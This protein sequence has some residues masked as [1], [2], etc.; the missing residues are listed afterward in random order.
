MA[1]YNASWTYRVQVTI[2][3][4]QVDSDLTDFPVYVDLS[5]LP[6][7]FFT[8]VDSAGD[9]IRVTRADGTTECAF[10]LVSINTGGSTGE[11]HFKANFI[12]STSDTSFYIY[13]GNAVA[14]AYAVGA[15]YGR[16]AV[17][18]DYDMVWHGGALTDSTGNQTLTANGGMTIGGSIGK[19]GSASSFDGTDD[20]ISFGSVFGNTRP[21]TF[22]AWAKLNTGEHIFASGGGKALISVSDTSSSSDQFLLFT[23]RVGSDSLWSAGVLE[24]QSGNPGFGTTTSSAGNVDDDVWEHWVGKI[25]S[26][27]SRTAYLNGTAGTENTYTQSSSSL[28]STDIGRLGDSTPNYY[29]DGDLCEVRVISSGLSSDWIAAEYTNQN[30]PNTFYTVGSQESGPT[31]WLPS[32]IIL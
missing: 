23:H 7:G 1:W 15:T 8:N 11:L 21:V 12:S 5:D 16:N 2:Q 4:S 10:E 30:T 27:S 9:D 22:S 29:W 25:T 31:G 17:W 32:V 18:S 26:T 19:L 3:S 13:Y 20:Y 14:S 6:A 28:N 24:R